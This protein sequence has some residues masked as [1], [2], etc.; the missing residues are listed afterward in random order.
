MNPTISTGAG[1]RNCCATCP[2]RSTCDYLRLR[3]Q[4]WER[5]VV[6]RNGLE[7]LIP[8]VLSTATSRVH[9][10][11]SRGWHA[12]HTWSPYHDKD[13]LTWAQPVD[14]CM[15][16]T[17][18]PPSFLLLLCKA[19]TG[20]RCSAVLQPTFPC[21]ITCSQLRAI[22][23][24]V[25]TA[26]RWVFFTPKNFKKLDTAGACTP[27]W[28]MQLACICSF[29]HWLW[30]EMPSGVGICTAHHFLPS[31]SHW[32][33]RRLPRPLMMTRQCRLGL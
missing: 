12:C 16:P 13:E 27:R 19:T 4:P 21:L 24:S 23:V 30:N 8:L 1:G 6:E 11:M 25:F 9:R 28:S 26:G 29:V 15:G 31:N 7:W 5:C 10:G 14:P 20:L 32:F 18:L 33:V 3:I 2:A 22:H 17:L